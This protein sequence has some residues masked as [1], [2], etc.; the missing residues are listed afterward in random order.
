M[1]NENERKPLRVGDCATTYAPVV[2]WLP[3]LFAF[4]PIESEVLPEREAEKY[5]SV[6]QFWKFSRNIALVAGAILRDR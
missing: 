1:P 2:T 4:L 3:S 6:S 5:E